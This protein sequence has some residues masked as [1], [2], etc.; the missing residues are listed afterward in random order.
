MWILI[1][2]G[3][4]LC[5]F[6]VIS[7]ILRAQVKA[8]TAKL[9]LKNKELQAEIAERKR[10]GEALRA[11]EERYRTL[12]KVLPIGI[13][14]TDAKGHCLYVNEH[15]CEIA[16]LTPEEAVGQGW[17]S[18]LYPDDHQRLFKE[19]S[20]AEEEQLP[21]KSE[22]RFERPDGSTAWVL[23][24]ATPVKGENGQVTGYVG[25]ITDIT[26]RKQAEQALQEGEERFR[27]VISSISDHIYVTE[28]A[29]DGRHAN[30][31]ISPNV[32][33]L[34]GYPMEKFM[35]DWTFWPS[36]VIHPD[37]R[38]RAAAQAKR[39]AMGQDS[40]VEYRMT[41]ADGKVIWVR[42]SGRVERKG[43]S[44]FIYGVV[45]DVTERRQLEE[46]LRQ[47]QK[48]EA[49][50][51]LAGGVAHDFNNILTVI[52]GYS[53]LLLYRYLDADDPQRKDVEQINQAAEQAATL[54]RQL[55]AFS[56]QQVLQLKILN[57]NRVVA[58]VENMLQRLI[59]ED[60]ELVT[61]LEPTLGQVKA[62]PGQMEQV[63]MNLAVNA[64]DA[65]PEGGKL[66]I[67]TGNVYLDEMYAG[68]HVGVESGPYVML[69]VSD[70]GTGI[71]EKTQAHIFE[72]F[73]TTKEQGQGTGLGLATVHGIIN[74]SGGHIWVYS[75]PGQGTT[76]KIYLPRVEA[77]V[78]S[79]RRSEGATKHTQGSETIL[80]VED[81]DSVRELAYRVLL[82]DGYTVLEAGDGA[83]ALRLFKQHQ[84]AIDLLLTDLVMPGGTSGRQLAEQLVS[85]CPEMKVLYMSGYTG[86]AIIHHGVLKPG[87]AFLQKP[88]SPD[89]LAG[90]VRQVLDA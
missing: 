6:L 52:I 78:E 30:H 69:A 86:K 9:L 70:S 89:A 54:T 75:K 62:D 82:R 60:I 81:E 14:H 83:E 87:M 25:T 77:E 56:R 63:I 48:M 17:A 67:E 68:Q 71:D 61:Y 21:F 55:L 59:G 47:S 3:G 28:V 23:G 39:L 34:T 53:E 49:I 36:S 7:I 19:W 57:L 26:E 20:Q 33:T 15:W 65:M 90:K 22:Y 16:G 31:Y 37:D 58:N 50:G 76:F 13:V 11:S 38:A 79:A 27:Q 84:G 66:T 4:L 2:V 35:A 1:S 51:R 73:F 18:S 5:L 32:E 24:Q 74:Q 43:T 72:P 80:L 41:R 88:F 46:Q 45:S 85:L 12:A 44:K 64:R 42:D 8:K 10:V 29:E 40:E